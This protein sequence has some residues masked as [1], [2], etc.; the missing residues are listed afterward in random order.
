MTKVY[1]AIILGGGASG[2]MA[3]IMAKRN[4]K[5]VIVVEKNQKL[6]KKILV[7]G[8]GRCN[9]ANENAIEDQKKPVHYFGQNPKFV[10]SVLN[11][12]G[13]KETKNFFSELG[14][15]FKEEDKG[16]LF[17]SSNQAQSVVD[18]LEYELQSLNIK[19]AEK[20]TPKKI[21]FNKKSGNYEV[22][23]SDGR[24]LLGEKLVIATGG[25]T[26]PD[27]GSNGDG[28]EY[29]KQFGHTILPTFPGYVAIRTKS[30]LCHILQGVKL[31]VGVKAYTN[32]KLIAE[33][34]GTIMF[35]HF[36]LSAPVILEISRIIAQETIVNK[37]SVKLTVNFLPDIKNED[38][39]KT[40]IKRWST[41]PNKPL[42]LSFIGLLPK[43][44]FPALLDVAGIERGLKCSDV[45]KELRGKIMKLLSEYEF[46]IDSV[47]DYKAAHF[48]AGGVNTKELNPKT[49]ESKLQEGLYFC[50]EVMDIDGICGGYNLQWA[51]STGAVVG[52]NI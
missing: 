9:I 37:N 48:T 26:L 4:G 51:W 16:R 2:M 7:T 41:S 33:N 35:A 34:T 43:K 29:A 15:V 19:I 25:L 6:G 11:Q 31:E 18:V 3:A 45:T 22:T 50:G 13:I 1:D 27:S 36:G 38:L 24:V 14:I 47:R 8:N 20:N 46:E 5:N 32:N 39:E 44:V 23:I 49:L 12:F 40:L 21:D 52:S 42:D 17:P 10:I 28:Y 30:P